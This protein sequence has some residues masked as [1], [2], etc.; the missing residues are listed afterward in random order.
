M[1]LRCCQVLLRRHRLPCSCQVHLQRCGPLRSRHGLPKQPEP[2]CITASGEES[3][4]TRLH[5]SQEGGTITKPPSG[6][7][8]IFGAR[9]VQSFKPFGACPLQSAK[10]HAKHPPPSTWPWVPPPSFV[11]TAD[12]LL[13]STLSHLG[14]QGPTYPS[15]PFVHGILGCGL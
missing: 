2:R 1:C 15:I 6:C 5:R 14:Q 10:Q 8:P 11:C 13:S 4:I 9:P 12:Y 3:I 7:T